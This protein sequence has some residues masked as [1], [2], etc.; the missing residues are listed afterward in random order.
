MDVDPVNEDA[1]SSV[2]SDPYLLEHIFALAQETAREELWGSADA[3][4]LRY[5]ARRRRMF[6]LHELGTMRPQAPS[7]I[8]ACAAG[9]CRKWRTAAHSSYAQ[10]LAWEITFDL[11]GRARNV[12]HSAFYF[13]QMSARHWTELDLSNAPNMHDPDDPLSINATDLAFILGAPTGAL[14]STR[15]RLQRL[16]LDGMRVNATHMDCLKRLLSDAHLS[17]EEVSLMDLPGAGS[18]TPKVWRGRFDV[19]LFSGIDSTMPRLRSLNL[20]GWFDDFAAADGGSH[21]QISVAR[22]LFFARLHEQI[23]DEALFAP[24]HVH[25]TELRDH[26]A[27]FDQAFVETIEWLTARA[28]ALESLQ[29]GWSSEFN[30]RRLYMWHAYIPQ[31]S[32]TALA[33]LVPRLTELDVSGIHFRDGGAREVLAKCTARLKSLSVNSCGLSDGDIEALASITSSLTFLNL[34]GNDKL[35]DHAVSSLLAR[36]P[37]LR[38]LNIGCTNLSARVLLTVVEN[39]PEL[40]ALDVCFAERISLNAI[41]AVIECFP[42]LDDLGISGFS[43][44]SDQKFDEILLQCPLLT[45]IG[46]SGCPQLTDR[47]LSAL[48]ERCG[49]RLRSLFAAH[50]DAFTAEGIASFLSGSLPKLEQASFEECEGVDAQFEKRYKLNTNLRYVSQF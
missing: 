25:M 46:V 2:L 44:L 13:A 12:S 6:E 35:N 18:C 22:Q 31:T 19:N 14:R 7:S 5:T 36:Q 10:F 37:Q 26:Y 33:E 30:H 28:P 24:T 23:G 50:N 42:N 49:S 41:V 39:C 27:T 15:S 48:S 45:S 40:T 38:S 21:E 29:L 47:A 34:R 4:A 3:S 16:V 32:S 1:T 8:I 43:D 17:L 9:V 20:K 11:G